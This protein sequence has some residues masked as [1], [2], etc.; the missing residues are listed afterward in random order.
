MI[1]LS[2]SLRCVNCGTGFELIPLPTATLGCP[3]CGSQHVTPID[4]VPRQEEET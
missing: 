1:D 3:H 2:R 4:R